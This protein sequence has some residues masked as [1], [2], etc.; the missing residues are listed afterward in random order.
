MAE[1]R[2]GTAE[3]YTVTLILDQA[4]ERGVFC[5]KTHALTGQTWV[6]VS[7]GS[8]EGYPVTGSGAVEWVRIFEQAKPPRGHYSVTPIADIPE[9]G[10]FAVRVE[11]ELG[12]TWSLKTKEGQSGWRQ[13]QWVHIAGHPT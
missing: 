2:F 6:L 1:Q 5:L 10:I 3:I 8:E 11:G 7:V 12:D 13:L 4:T 9:R